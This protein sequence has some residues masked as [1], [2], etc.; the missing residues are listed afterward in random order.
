MA[1]VDIDEDAK[2]AMVEEALK[3]ELPTKEKNIFNQCVE[4]EAK[5]ISN[6]GQSFVNKVKYIKRVS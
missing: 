3:R 5:L 4:E 6:L 1:N 2:E